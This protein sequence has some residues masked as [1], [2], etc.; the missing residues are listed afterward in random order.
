MADAAQAA[1]SLTADATAA[2]HTAPEADAEALQLCFNGG[3]V[4]CRAALHQLL[5]QWQ[6]RMPMVAPAEPAPLATDGRPV[7]GGLSHEICHAQEY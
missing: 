3:Q 1:L 4:G 6:A 7:P 5:P 2:C